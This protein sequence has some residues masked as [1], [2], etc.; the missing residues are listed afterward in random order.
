MQFRKSS[1][2]AHYA[3]AVSSC[4]LLLFTANWLTAAQDA[5]APAATPSESATATPAEKTPSDNSDAA[6]PVGL[7]T[8][9]H[10]QLIDHKS[11]SAEIEQTVNFGR[12]R[13]QATGRYTTSGTQLR[14]EFQVQ[15]ADGVGGSLLEVCD[16]D[17]LWSYTKIMDSQRLT[18]RDIKQI[19]NAAAASGASPDALLSAELALG[20]VPSLLA[21]CQKH[22]NFD[23]LKRE[24]DAAGRATTV[25]QGR[26]KQEFAKKWQLNEQGD[27]PE[28]VPDQ[29]RIVFAADTLFPQRFLFLKK[30]PG[31]ASFRPLVDLR[32]TN[33]QLNGEVDDEQFRFVPPDGAVPENTTREYLELIRQTRGDVKAP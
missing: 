9:A 15:L 33:V 8:R 4:A 28:Y 30:S 14:L 10:R 26:W 29:I 18:R 23:A 24:A 7:V 20:G 31:K 25:V 11:V 2:P 22:L 19:L 27:L 17:V 16:G 12:Q 3:M 21:A 5:A 32:F 1:L 13:F 6:S